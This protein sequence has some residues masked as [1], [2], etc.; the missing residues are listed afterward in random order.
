MWGVG[1]GRENKCEGK[2]LFTLTQYFLS[3][4]WE[5]FQFIGNMYVFWK[6]WLLTCYAFCEGVTNLS[7]NAFVD[8]KQLCLQGILEVSNDHL[9]LFRTL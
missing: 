2:K 8:N 6:P 5:P 4:C 1:G 3:S 9:A 7:L